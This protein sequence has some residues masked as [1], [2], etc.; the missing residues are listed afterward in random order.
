MILVLTTSKSAVDNDRRLSYVSFNEVKP[1]L[2]RFL[3]D[4]CEFNRS[5][6]WSKNLLGLYTLSDLKQ[7]Q[8]CL[9]G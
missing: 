9:E 6:P 3:K 8:W 2:K 7:C 1:L 5:C 4:H